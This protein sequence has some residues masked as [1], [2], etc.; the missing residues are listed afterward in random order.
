MIDEK[1][2]PPG[3]GVTG[4]LVPGIPTNVK[5]NILIELTSTSLA[6]YQVISQASVGGRMNKKNPKPVSR[7]W[8]SLITR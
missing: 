6:Y 5:Y 2:R 1:P 8:D 7:V 3:D 4:L